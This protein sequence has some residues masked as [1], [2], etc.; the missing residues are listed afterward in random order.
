MVGGIVPPFNEREP[1]FPLMLLFRGEAMKISFQTFVDNFGL[2]I[3]LWRYPELIFSLV[4]VWWNSYVQ[5]WLVKVVSRSKTMEEGMPWRRNIWSMKICPAEKEVYGWLRAKKW[6][7]LESRSTTTKITVFPPDLGSP[8]IKSIEISIKG[9]GS[10]KPRRSVVSPLWHCQL[11]HLA[12]IYW[13]SHFIPSQNKLCCA[14]FHVL[15][16]VEC[17]VEGEAWSS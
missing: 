15:R 17:P 13:I 1:I 7:Y 9:K 16:N 2:I 14:C 3:C 5:K 4:S 12:T 6:L 10:S 8:S 11:S